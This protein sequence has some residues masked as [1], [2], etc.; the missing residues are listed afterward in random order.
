MTNKRT[1][2][3][4]INAFNKKYNPNVSKTKGS[5]LPNGYSYFGCNWVRVENYGKIDEIK[6][7]TGEDI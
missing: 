6:R 1:M 7:I 3:K 4:N 5:K 2:F